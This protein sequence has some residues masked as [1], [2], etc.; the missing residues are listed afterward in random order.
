[1]ET[2]FATNNAHKVAEVAEILGPGFTVVTPSSL[3]FDGDI[4]ETSPTLEGNSLQKAQFIWDK[5]HKNCFADD[6]GL[7]IDAL[8]GAPGVL[9]ARFAGPQKD[10][11]DNRRKV[12][13]LLKGVPF[14]ERTARFRCVVTY[15]K[16][17][18]PTVFEGVCEG[19]IALGES[20]GE[21]GFGYDSIFV[22]QDMDVTM[23]EISPEAKNA[24][25]HRGK[26]MRKLACHLSQNQGQ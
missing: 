4:P 6:T 9:S 14:G 17:G 1:M 24:I 26:A 15:I 16:D 11:A 12:L 22:P 5:F 7:E 3:G 10:S 25:S 23:A 21:H 18:V 20:N 13:A 2:V 8:D 19:Y